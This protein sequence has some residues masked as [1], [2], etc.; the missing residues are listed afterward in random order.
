MAP[1]VIEEFKSLRFLAFEERG[2]QDYPTFNICTSDHNRGGLKM[3][4][5]DTMID[6]KRLSWLKRIVDP[7][8]SSFWRSYLG[9]LFQN[10]AG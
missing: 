2:R 4:D 3:T 9:N 7:D 8:F 6:T 5:Y 1:E 10:G